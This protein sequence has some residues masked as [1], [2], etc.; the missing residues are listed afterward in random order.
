MLLTSSNCNY[1]KYDR[2]LAPTLPLVLGYSTSFPLPSFTFLGGC[3]E[4]SLA[5][6]VGCCIVGRMG[7]ALIMASFHYLTLSPGPFSPKMRGYSPREWKPFSSTVKTELAAATIEKC[8]VCQIWVT[9]DFLLLPLE[10]HFSIFLITDFLCVWLER[11]CI[12]G[13]GGCLCSPSEE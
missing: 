4:T 8:L 11:A 3:E 12:V 1:Q 2:I 9:L 13:P 7:T 10:P 6:A 5:G